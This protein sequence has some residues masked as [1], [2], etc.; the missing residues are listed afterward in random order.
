MRDTFRS[1]QWDV[2][3]VESDGYDSATSTTAHQA[4]LPSSVERESI[5]STSSKHDRDDAFDEDFQERMTMEE[6]G[7]PSI[8]KRR[9]TIEPHTPDTPPHDDTPG[10]PHTEPSQTNGTR[11]PREHGRCVQVH[12]RVDAAQGARDAAQ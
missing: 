12:V 11:R 1:G 2:R 5:P 4:S 10:T 6:R 9:L 7:R 3:E 8:K